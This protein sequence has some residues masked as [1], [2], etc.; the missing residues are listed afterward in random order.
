MKKWEFII[1]VDVS[2]NTLDV[3]C[4]ERD[5]YVQIKNGKEGFRALEKWC[6]ANR[7]ELAK[8]MVVMEYTGGYEYKLVSFCE[9]KGILYARVPGLEIK[10]SLGIARGKNDRVDAKR[11]A[12][13]ADQRHKTIRP[14]RPLDHKVK[15]LKEL[16]GFRKALV[17]EKAGHQARIKERMHMYPDLK[18]DFILQES[19]RRSRTNEAAIKRADREIAELIKSDGAM[20]ANYILITSIKGVGPVNAAMTISYTENFTGFPDARSYAVYVGVV[21]FDHISG[22]SIRGRKRVSHLAN[23]KLKAE[24]TQAAK[25]AMQHDPEIKAYAERKLLNKPYGLVVNNV[26]F[27]IILR[28][29]AV[30]KRGSKFVENYKN[31]A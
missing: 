19:R 2:R 29:F 20:W 27:K 26:K 11:I 24:L 16:L 28:I 30:V 7:I 23:I 8:S 12:Q 17:R 25:S 3:H 4:P 13:Y 5:V 15:A 21:P 9:A 14:S 1:G 10:R 22:T 6:G 18:K 31:V